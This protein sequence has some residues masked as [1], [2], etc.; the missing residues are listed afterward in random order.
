MKIGLVRFQAL[1]AANMKKT[2]FLDVPPCSLEETDL[3][4]FQ[5]CLL[6]PSLIALMMEAISTSETSIN[7]YETTRRNI[8][9]DGH[10]QNRFILHTPV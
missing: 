1:M 9:E 5:N 10:L 7:F 4:T 2:V 6:L 8:P 3:R